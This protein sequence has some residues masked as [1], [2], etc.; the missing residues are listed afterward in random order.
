NDQLRELFIRFDGLAA[1]DGSARFGF[2]DAQAIATLSGPIEVRLASEQPSQATLEVHLRPLSGV[3]ATESK[4]LAST[5]SS[6][7]VPSLILTQNPRTLVQLAIQTIS[8]ATWRDGLVASMINASSLAFISAGSVPMKGVVCAVAVGRISSFILDPSDAETTSLSAG[9]C[10]AFLVT[11]S[12]TT[13]VWTNWR[14][15]SQ[16]GFDEKE[17]VQARDLARTAAKKVALGIK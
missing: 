4:S 2:G 17:L 11:D 6:S 15:L 1:V 5:I 12:D 3:S 13:C 14:S 9:G 8:S 10:F 16:G 7:L